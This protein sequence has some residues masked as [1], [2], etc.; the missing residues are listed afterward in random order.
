MK[1]G[2]IKKLGI[3]L[4]KC[5][6]SLMDYYKVDS[7][8]IAHS[9]IAIRAYMEKGEYGKAVHNWKNGSRKRAL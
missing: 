6:D 2:K 5:F 8:W 1:K 4:H 7:L 3:I 9:K